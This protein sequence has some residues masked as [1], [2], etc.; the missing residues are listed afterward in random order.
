MIYPY[1][2]LTIIIFGIIFYLLLFTYLIKKFNIKKRKLIPLI[3]MPLF[4]FF[5]YLIL[6]YGIALIQGEEIFRFGVF[7]AMFFIQAPILIIMLPALIAFSLGVTILSQE[8]KLKSWRLFFVAMLVAGMS[9]SIHAYFMESLF[10]IIFAM[11][12]GTVSVMIQYYRNK[13]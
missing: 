4:L 13:I 8:L 3:F 12:L 5:I 11:L 9:T 2:K 7:M 1:L 6:S 10:V